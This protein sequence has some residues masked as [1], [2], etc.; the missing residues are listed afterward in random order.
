MKTVINRVLAAAFLIGLAAWLPPAVAADPA[1]PKVAENGIVK[2]KSAFA[3]HET[4]QRLKKD[5]EAKGIMF[6]MAVEQ[7]KL[8]EK[9]NIK[10][11]PSTLLIFGNPPLGVQFLTANP[12]AGLDWPVRLLV[13]QDDAGQVWMTYTDFFYIARRHNITNRNEAF[14]M[15]T[16][17]IASITSAAM[18]GNK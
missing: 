13:N 1:A 2:V 18:A 15:A 16:K 14:T 9:A 3:F 10:L 6:F 12:D 11:N 5:I 4:V 17:V 8:A 7:S